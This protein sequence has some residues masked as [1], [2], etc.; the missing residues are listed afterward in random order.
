ME[1]TETKR[2]DRIDMDPYYYAPE[3]LSSVHILVMSHYAVSTACYTHIGS[4]GRGIVV[5]T[6]LCDS[7][8]HTGSCKTAPAP[9]FVS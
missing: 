9:T 8:K 3:V 2:D 7:A 5:V 4:M 1:Y 6:R